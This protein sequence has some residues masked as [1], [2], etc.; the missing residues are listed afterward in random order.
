ME[1]ASLTEKEFEN[2]MMPLQMQQRKGK[3][4]ALLSLFM[5]PALL[6]AN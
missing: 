1:L 3:V 5:A 4:T 2:E 6:Q